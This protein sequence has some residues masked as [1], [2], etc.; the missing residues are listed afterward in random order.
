LK[1]RQGIFTR[2]SP[3]LPVVSDRRR[4]PEKGGRDRKFRCKNG[5][6]LQASASKKDKVFVENQCTHL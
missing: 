4:F 2:H 6:S 3:A 5:I 1:Y